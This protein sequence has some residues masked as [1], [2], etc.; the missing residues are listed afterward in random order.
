[1]KRRL[2]DFIDSIKGFSSESKSQKLLNFVFFA[3]EII[4][5][6]QVTVGNLKQLFD[7]ADLPTPRNFGGEISH[8][9]RKKQLIRRKNGYKLSRAAKE[10]IKAKLYPQSPK[11]KRLKETTLSLETLHPAIKKVSRKLF[12]DGHYSQAIF[13]A[14]K[15]VVNQVKKISGVASLDGKPLMENVF[16]LSKPKIKLNRLQSQSDKDEQLGFMFLFSGAALGI[17][18][19]KA[20]DNIIQ[21]DPIKALEYLSFASLL[22]KRLDKRIKQ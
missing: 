5:R 8:L 21:K 17:R 13:E 1:M 9:L 3:T 20:H 22:L 6:E 14:Y 19:P 16:S 11:G 7:L 15:T 4:R 18:N 2:D 10:S 12:F